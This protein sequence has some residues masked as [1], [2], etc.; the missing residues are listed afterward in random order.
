MSE[1]TQ[2]AGGETRQMCTPAQRLGQAAPAAGVARTT[3]SPHHIY[4]GGSAACHTA[5]VVVVE[6]VA[7]VVVVVLVLFVVMFVACTVWGAG[8]QPAPVCCKCDSYH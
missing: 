8:Q 3:P 6:V 7:V 2:G 1:C 5:A 4:G